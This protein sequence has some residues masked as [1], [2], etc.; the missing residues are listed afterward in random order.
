MA[1]DKTTFKYHALDSSMVIDLLYSTKNI[2]EFIAGVEEIHSPD[3]DEIQTEAKA[4][5]LK[6][7]VNNFHFWEA[8]SET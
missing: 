2:E 6:L 4:E 8:E 1:A 3:P 5:R 7:N